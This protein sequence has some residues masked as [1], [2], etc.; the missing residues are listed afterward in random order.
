MTI[1]PQTLSPAQAAKRLGLGKTLTMKLI[2]DG[3]LPAKRLGN[4]I[5]VTVVACDA[6]IAAL[7]AVSP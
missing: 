1:E 4:R 5:R 3:R 7:P 6:F 2:R